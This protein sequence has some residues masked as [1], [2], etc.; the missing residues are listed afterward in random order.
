MRRVFGYLKQNYKFSIN[1]DIKE[2]DLSMHKIDEYDWFPL[3]GNT[4]EEE[5]YG[6]L[7]PKGKPVV[8]SG[9]FDSSH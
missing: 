6:M 2:P 7:E 9:F 3:Y 5:L 4:K 8:T 1:C